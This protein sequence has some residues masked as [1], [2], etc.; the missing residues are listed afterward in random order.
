MLIGNTPLIKF[1]DI[2]IKLESYNLSGS[3]KDRV[4]KILL[5]K[6][7]NKLNKDSIVVVPS[8]GNLGISIACLCSINNINCEVIIPNNV[9]KERIKRLKMYNANLI[10]VSNMKEANEIAINKSKQDNYFLID[11]FNDINNVLTHYNTTA[12]EIEKSLN[13]KVDFLVLGIGSGGT[14]SGVGKRLK[15]NNSNMKIIG[16]LPSNNSKID[17]IGAGFKPSILNEKIID[18]IYHVDESSALKQMLFLYKNGIN[19]GLSSGAV[20][21]VCLKIKEKNHNKCI[22]TIFPDSVEK[23]LSIVL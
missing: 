9:S 8:S 22:V 15:E 12:L 20:Y 18:E 17:G 14:I 16:V 2:Y 19:A 13:I 5:D 1:N 4:A 11:Q 21:D 23:Y 6:I 3:I 7:I 10:Y